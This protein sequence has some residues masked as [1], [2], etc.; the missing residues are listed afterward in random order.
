M[1]KQRVGGQEMMVAAAA[2][3]GTVGIALDM[4][5]IRVYIFYYDFHLWYKYVKK[6]QDLDRG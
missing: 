5:I 1:P 2:A 6:M 3:A 4:Y